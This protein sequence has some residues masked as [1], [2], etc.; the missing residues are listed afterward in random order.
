MF[1]LACMIGT[2]AFSQVGV[3]TASPQTT[4]DITAENTD[5]TTAEGIIAPRLTGDQIKGKDAKYTVA[6]TGAFVY[7]TAAVTGTPAGKTV[8]ITTTGYYYFD[9]SLWQNVAKAAVVFTA[10]LGSGSGSVTSATVAQNGFNTVPLPNITRNLG[11]GTWTASNN[12]Y[13]VPISGTY[14]IKSSIR[15]VDNSASR[16]VFQAV[17]TTNADIPDGI[18]QTNPSGAQRWTMLYTRLAYFNEGDLLRL[19]MFSDGTVANL[20]DAS[21]NIALL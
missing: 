14:I 19:Y 13:R 12:T 17:G 6:Q 11:G 5:A 3:N 16:N 9:G 18:W 20:S 8:N 1:S 7:V 4:L 10:S 2:A 15:L 21:L